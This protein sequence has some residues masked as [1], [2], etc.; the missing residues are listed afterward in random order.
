MRRIQILLLA[1]L[2]TLAATAFAQA[3][4]SRQEA[5]PGSRQEASPGSRQEAL[6]SLGSADAAARAAGVAW[7]ARNGAEAD[8][9]PLY[10]RLRDENPMVRSYAEQALWMLW[11]RSGD[12]ALDRLLERGVDEMQSGRHVEAIATF[13]EVIRR[14]PAFAEGWNKRATA[15]YLSGEYQRS[16]ADCAE[17][18]K[19]NPRHFGALSGAGLNHLELEE[20]RQ[21]LGWFRRALEVN[22]NMGSIDAEVRRL[23]ELLRGRST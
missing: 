17:V 2:T 20:Q 1:A 7:I 12:E 11:S 23:E 15:L 19:R 21:A 16:L 8:A 5:S 9:A 3:P 18:I 4:G 6:R 10:E 13:S 14:N 22:P